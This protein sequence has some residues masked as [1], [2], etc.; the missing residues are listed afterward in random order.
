[1]EYI[2]SNTDILNEQIGVLFNREILANSGCF[3]TGRAYRMVVSFNVNLLHDRRFEEFNVP[4]PSKANAGTEMER[5]YDVLWHQLHVLEQILVNNG[6][7]V[8]SASIQGEDLQE[9]PIVKIEMT[10]DDANPIYSGRGKKKKQLKVFSI[11]PSRPYITGIASKMAGK[12]LG[13]IYYKIM[14]IVQDK[15]RM[16]KVLG[17]AETEDNEILINA[18]LDQYQELWLVTGEKKMELANRLQ[19]KILNVMFP[20]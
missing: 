20:K 10:E 9:E 5:I 11:M 12:E 19:D 1:M 18:F 2:L 8:N 14:D 7:E 3:V 6:I 17:V 4:L 13:E 16:S 15:K